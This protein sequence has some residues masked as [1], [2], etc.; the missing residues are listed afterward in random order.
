MN[1][2]NYHNK[3]YYLNNFKA[4]III[5]NKI[6]KVLLWDYKLYIFYSLKKKVL[7]KQKDKSKGVYIYIYIGGNQY[8]ANIRNIFAADSVKGVQTYLP[9][10]IY[11]AYRFD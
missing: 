2:S 7:K 1:V 6:I 10:C 4:Q 5:F 11:I 9:N 3:N 8:Y